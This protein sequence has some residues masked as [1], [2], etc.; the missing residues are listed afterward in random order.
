MCL[1]P[2]ELSY[3]HL[4]DAET[5]LGTGFRDELGAPPVALRA[6]LGM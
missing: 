4:N 3:F 6:V 5:S 1:Q 2:M